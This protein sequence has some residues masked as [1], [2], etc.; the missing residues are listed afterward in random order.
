MEY[1]VSRGRSLRL[2]NA[3][4]CSTPLSSSRCLNTAP[5]PLS[6]V[7]VCRMNSLGP[8]VAGGG[9]TITAATDVPG[10]PVLAGDHRRKS[11]LSLHSFCFNFSLYNFRIRNAF[12]DSEKVKLWS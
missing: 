12:L 8:C 6:D 1:H 7:S 4:G 5:I 11:A 3:T 10:G 2:Q 9:G